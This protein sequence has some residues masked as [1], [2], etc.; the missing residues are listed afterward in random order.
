MDRAC[1][2]LPRFLLL[3]VLVALSTLSGCVTQPKVRPVAARIAGVDPGGVR[4]QLYV[5]VENDNSFDIQVRGIRATVVIENRYNLPPVVATP[6]QWLRAGT[7]TTVEVPMRIPFTM[8]QPLLNTTLGKRELTYK[9]YGSADV[10]ATSSLR[11]DF[12]DY[13]MKGA[14]ETVNRGELAGLALNGLLRPP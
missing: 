3:L 14:K 10:T 8:V 4:F 9:V 5:A 12:D 6:N 7:T 1:A 11:I 13:K 2:Y